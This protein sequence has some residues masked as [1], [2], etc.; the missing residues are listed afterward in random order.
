MAANKSFLTLDDVDLAGKRVLARVDFNVPV[1]DGKVTDDT[2]IRACLPTIERITGAGAMLMLMSHLGRPKAG[3]FDP[4][5]SLRPVAEHLSSLLASRVD[6][7]DDWSSRPFEPARVLMMENVRFLAGETANDDGLAREMAALC[8]VYVN[9]AF[10][11]AHRA[12]ASTHGV[13]KF[14]PVACA[15][16]LVVREIEALSAAFE[17]PARPMAAVVGG[18][19]VSTKLEVLRSLV[20]KVDQLILGGGIANTFL[21]AAGTGIGKSL[22]EDELVDTA[23]EIMALAREQDKAIPLPEDVICA[24]SLDENA[25][26]AVKPVTGVADDDLILDIGPKTANLYASILREAK[27]IIWNGPVGVF[28]IE[29]FSE[30]T[31]A[32]ARAVAGSEAFS[33]AGGGD[34]IAAISKFGVSGEISYITTAGGAFLEFL[35]GKTLPA[36]AMLEECARLKRS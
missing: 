1:K 2:R 13:A 33:V 19:K 5:S 24:K 16:P 12:H 9:D 7:I 6:L 8:D 26:A 34:T 25:K 22:C 30:G 3:Q 18:A 23:A 36:I 21:K 11:A 10:A 15:G 17:S 4:G 29:Q 14:A 20:R 31:R 32:V 35:E 27:T 28:E